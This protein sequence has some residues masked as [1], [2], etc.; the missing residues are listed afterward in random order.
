MV[1]KVSLTR[2]R[3]TV[4]ID[5]DVVSFDVRLFLCIEGCIW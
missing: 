1:S 5:F 3:E 2:Q 4:D